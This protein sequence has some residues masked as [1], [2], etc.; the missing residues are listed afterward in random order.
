M[1]SGPEKAGYC[2]ECRLYRPPTLSRGEYRRRRCCIIAKA[3]PL[4]R[5]EMCV[6]ARPHLSNGLDQGTGLG[7]H[8]G[9]YVMTVHIFHFLA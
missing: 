2:I 6:H 8:L 4:G 5:R 7:T 3:G 1:Q 9:C